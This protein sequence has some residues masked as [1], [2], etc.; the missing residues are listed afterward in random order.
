MPIEL[1]ATV[2]GAQGTKAR[3]NDWRRFYL[4]PPPETNVDNKTSI[5]I[6]TEREEILQGVYWYDADGFNF[7]CNG[8]WYNPNDEEWERDSPDGTIFF[9]GN[10]EGYDIECLAPTR[11]C[12]RR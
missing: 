2:S 3:T 9:Q 11:S 5:L 10:S 8:G 7:Q 12:W 1:K 4:E 6:E